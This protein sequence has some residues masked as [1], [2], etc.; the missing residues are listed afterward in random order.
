[1]IQQQVCVGVFAYA[2]VNKWHNTDMCNRVNS[3][4]TQFIATLL[5]FE[6]SRL[7]MYRLLANGRISVIL[8]S[9][10]QQEIHSGLQLHE[11]RPTNFLFSFHKSQYS[12]HFFS[13]CQ[14][15]IH[16]TTKYSTLKEGPFKRRW[17]KKRKNNRPFFAISDSFNS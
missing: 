13:I 6:P 8:P 2:Y 11:L 10:R 9:L 12:S 3:R 5:S 14:S 16:F 15:K 17:K 1:M 4:I 7:H